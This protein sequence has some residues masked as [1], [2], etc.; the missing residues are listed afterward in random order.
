MWFREFIREI[1]GEP[2]EKIIDIFCDNNGSICV[3]RYR[4][5][6]TR[7]KH[8]NIRHHFIRERTENK[9]INLKY[10]QTDEMIA[11]SFT[12]TLPAPRHFYLLNKLGLCE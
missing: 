7:T 10:L 6:N 9:H 3:S 5:T 12:K 2:K 8:I 1:T 11:D 4:I